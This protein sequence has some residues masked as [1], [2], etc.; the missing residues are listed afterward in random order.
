MSWF[1]KMVGGTVGLMIGGPLGAIA[2]GAIGHHLFDKG[3]GRAA[4]GRRVSYQPPPQ[5][6]GAQQAPPPPRRSEEEERQ[7]T[8]FLALFSILGKLAKADGAV[9]RDEG[10]ML[11]QFLGEMDLSG[12]EREF[13]IK[14]FNE[15]K[16]SRFT[17]EDFARQFADATRGRQQLRTSLMDMLFRIAAADGTVHPAE[18]AMIASIGRTL[19]FSAL[20]VEQLKKRYAGDPDQAYAVLGVSPDA[21]DGEVRDTYRRLV[22]EYHPDTVIG[23]G[24]PEEFVQYATKRFQEV[25]T[26]WETVKKSRGL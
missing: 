21:S 23:Q 14:V 17:V 18:E 15:A 6:S 7:A 1:G 9:T 22:Q 11:V 8:F 26:A 16:N 12:K 10:D 20:D 24:M 4:S 25:Q 3:S 5:W 2:G 19:G 13:A